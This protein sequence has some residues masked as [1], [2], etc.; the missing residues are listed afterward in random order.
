MKQSR[1]AVTAVALFVALTCLPCLIW[2]LF[3][4]RLEGENTENRNLSELPALTL[5]G[6]SDYPAALENYFNDHLPF[7]RQ[8]IQANSA[9]RYYGFASSMSDKVALGRDG[10]LFY[11][12][13][14]S[15][16]FY[17][18]QKRY[19]EEELNR[20]VYNMQTL[21]D[22]LEARGT[23]FVLFIPPNKERMYAEYLPASFGERADDCALFQV[24]AALEERST[25][26]VVCPYETL[27]IA[28]G[29]EPDRLLYHKTD[30]HWN[31][32]GAYLGVKDLLRALYV[33]W[34]ESGLRVETVPDQ[35]GDLADMLNLAGLL[36]PGSTCTVSGYERA[37]T[38]LQDYDFFGDIRFICPSREAEG[39]LLMCRDSFCSAMAPVLGHAFSETVLTHLQAF[40]R[41][42]IDPEKPDIF[43]LELVERNLDFLLRDDLFLNPAE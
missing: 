3:S 16:G 28:E 41:D 12:A 11:T 20:I 1:K 33:P 31:D 13:E 8:L 17:N 18:G 24:T 30:T 19:T 42:K 14:S 10:W 2:P 15:P 34:D 39:K 40:T 23:R 32:W 6:L 25:V 36:D 26:R 38:V 5:S 27:I 21:K 35:P 29:E 43:V 9:L 22:D 7:R 4:A 37:D